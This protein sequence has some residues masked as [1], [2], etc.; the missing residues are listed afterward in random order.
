MYT[1]IMRGR[2]SLLSLSILSWTF[3]FTLSL[4]NILRV[5]RGGK[6][7][8]GGGGI[9]EMDASQ[10]SAKKGQKEMGKLKKE[11]KEEST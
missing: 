11:Q 3:F 8:G 6:W 10:M 4:Q 2:P 1:L 9:M 5:R 7:D